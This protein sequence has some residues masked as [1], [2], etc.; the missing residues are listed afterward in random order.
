MPNFYSPLLETQ[1]GQPIWDAPDYWRQPEDQRARRLR[2]ERDDKRLL[3][4]WF[5]D[6]GIL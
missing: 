4:R 5:R 1:Q 6:T 3:R 2:A